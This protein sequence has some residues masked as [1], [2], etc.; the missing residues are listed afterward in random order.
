MKELEQDLTDERRRKARPT[1]FEFAL[2]SRAD[3]L[4]SLGIDGRLLG[5]EVPSDI[6]D[7]EAGP[8]KE[9][10]APRRGMGRCVPT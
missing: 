10:A 1:N 4:A 5:G 9:G 7:P 6:S 8:K 2:P 3:V